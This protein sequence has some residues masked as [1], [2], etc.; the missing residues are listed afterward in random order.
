MA[1][2]TLDYLPYV[3]DFDPQDSNKLVVGGG[4]GANRSG[5]ANRIVRLRERASHATVASHRIAS[6][7][8]SSHL[9]SHR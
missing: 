9:I 4:G 2:A 8:T 5:V 1:R 6:H 7:G 3:C